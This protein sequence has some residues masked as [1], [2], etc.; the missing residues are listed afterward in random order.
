VLNSIVSGSY[1][2]GVVRQMFPGD[3]EGASKVTLSPSIG[4]ALTAAVAGVL[5]FGVYPMPLIEAAQEAVA[6]LAVR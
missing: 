6:V 5:I 3:A 1:S 2:L 4:L